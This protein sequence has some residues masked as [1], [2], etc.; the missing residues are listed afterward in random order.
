M[1]EPPDP[2]PPAEDEFRWTAWFQRSPQPLFV[3]SRRRQ[4]L[5]VNRAW[6]ALTGFR[7]ADV[8]KRVCRRQRDTEAGSAE[9]MLSALCPPR[10]AL[11]G[12]ASEVRRSVA[13]ATGPQWWDIGYWPLAGPEG[14]LGLLG[15]IAPVANAHAG[16]RQALPEKLVALRERQAGQWRLGNLT[17]EIPA[18]RLVQEQVRL[19]AQGR[20]SVL[21]VGEPGTGKQWVARTIHQES[22]G[23]EGS[24][25]ALDC[26]HLPAGALAWALFG[27]PGVGQ[28]GNVTLY[29]QE[30][31]ALPRELQDRLCELTL[32]GSS[33]RLLS[34]FSTDPAAEVAS[35]RLLP[36]LHCL[37][38]P[39][40]IRLPPLRDRRGDLPALVRTFLER[41]GTGSDK[42][43]TDLSAE[44]WELLQA[45]GWPGNLRELFAVMAA[46]CGRA[47]SARL[48]VA[49]LPWYLRTPA[50]LPERTVALDAILEQVERRLIQ[51]ALVAAKGNKS[52]AAELL[53]IWRP[54]LL[55][56]MEA[57][58]IT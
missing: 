13:A 8:R 52:R 2:V 50:P 16:G 35:G 54:R 33:P 25:V 44:A 41:L 58:G 9:A 24:F 55:R 42:T 56:R 49:D 48:E 28:R 12:K 46:A 15:K 20:V 4:I 53:T 38:G 22:A 32:A 47:K 1:T 26:Q 57:L 45:Y 17:S 3:L 34:G 23:R 7:F 39:L 5:F 6:E 19:A 21:L 29:L 18:M 14:V 10:E 37:L 31:A 11:A 40:T 30:P 51:V 43:V 27:P 36:E